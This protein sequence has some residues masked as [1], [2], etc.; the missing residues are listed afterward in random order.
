VTTSRQ[1]VAED[2]L[3]A[4]LQADAV[5][6]ALA[7]EPRFGTPVSPMKEHVWIPESVDV[8]R[9][10]SLTGGARPEQH[11]TFPIRVVVFVARTGDDMA[12]ARN[13]ST[14]LV[15]RIED[16]LAAN[17]HLGLTQADVYFA[18]V[19]RIERRAGAWDDQVGIVKTV[20]ISVEAYLPGA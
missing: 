17:T 14:E 10:N 12:A 7:G 20:E 2:A 9:E 5:L 3:L 6:G 15:A 4:L 18:E 11:E 19:T 1:D 8:E 16:L 13:R